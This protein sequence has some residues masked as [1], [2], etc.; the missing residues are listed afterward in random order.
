MLEG[1]REHLLSNHNNLDSEI[2]KLPEAFKRFIGQKGK[3]KT[4]KEARRVYTRDWR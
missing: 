3:K 1:K 2:E 4:R